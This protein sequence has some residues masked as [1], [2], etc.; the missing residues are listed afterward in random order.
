MNLTPWGSFVHHYTAATPADFWQS[1]RAE[2]LKAQEQ[3]ADWEFLLE[4]RIA[5]MRELLG[6]G[7]R[8]EIE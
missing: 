7:K 3:D 1:L 6:M 5:G 4:E 8:G 2:V